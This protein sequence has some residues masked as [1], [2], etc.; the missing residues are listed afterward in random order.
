MFTLFAEGVSCASVLL[1]GISELAPDNGA[2]RARNVMVAE[3]HIHHLVKERFN[4]L[5]KIDESTTGL[6]PDQDINP[7]LRFLLFHA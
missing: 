4:H 2:G 6:E 1:C 7:G 3:R 5:N